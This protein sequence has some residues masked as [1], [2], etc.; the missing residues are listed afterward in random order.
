LRISNG[1]TTGAPHRAGDFFGYINIAASTSANGD[2]ILIN[3]SIENVRTLAGCVCTL[4][5]WA[6]TPG[7][8]RSIS[9][10]IARSYGTGGSP[11]LYESAVAVKKFTIDATWRKFSHTF[12]MPTLVGKTFGTA[13]DDCVILLLWLS[14]GANWNARTA[15]LGHQN[16]GDIYFSQIQ[17][18]EGPFATPF[19]RRPYQLELEL[20]Q[21]YYEGGGLQLG[22]PCPSAGGFAHMFAVPFKAWKRVVPTM[23]ALSLSSPSNIFSSGF[24]Q[25]YNAGFSYQLV[26]TNFTNSMAY[27]TWEAKAEF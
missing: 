27:L 3:Q 22:F 4:S 1:N 10:E 9:A 11:S 17:L 5:F 20:C 24:Y 18:E 6:R 2:Y 15:S 26:G 12:T 23:T 19:E 21:R 13:N 14:A 7:V 8:A 16:L 25:P